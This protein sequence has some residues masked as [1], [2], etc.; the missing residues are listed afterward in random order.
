[1][2]TFMCATWERF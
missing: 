1:M 2:Q